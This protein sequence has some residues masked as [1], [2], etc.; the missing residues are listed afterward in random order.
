M[1]YVQRHDSE[2]GNWFLLRVVD[3]DVVAIRDDK[4]GPFFNADGSSIEEIEPVEIERPIVH[5]ADPLGDYR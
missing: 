3:G 1:K 2:T 5:Y 4:E